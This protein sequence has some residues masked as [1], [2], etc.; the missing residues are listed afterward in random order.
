MHFHKW[1]EV[2]ERKDGEINIYKICKYCGVCY[3]LIGRD[4][5][6]YHD[7]KKNIEMGSKEETLLYPCYILKG[8]ELVRIAP[9]MAWDIRKIQCHHYV[10]VQYIRNHPERKEELQAIQKLIFL[11][12]ECHAELHRGHSKFKQKYGIE[13]GELLYDY[14]EN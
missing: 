5:F 4:W 6:L 1:F 12:P 14:A 3:K 11:T 2:E 9:P 13:L 10:R 7:A 8:G